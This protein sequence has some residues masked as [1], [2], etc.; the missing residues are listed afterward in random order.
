MQQSKFDSI[1][2]LMA[3]VFAIVMLLV[4]IHTCGKNGQLTIDY[5]KMKEEVQSYKVQH[6]SDSTKSNRE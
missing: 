3:I 5:R 4:F 6:L 2:K 1:D